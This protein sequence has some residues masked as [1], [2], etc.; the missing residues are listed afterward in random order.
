MRRLACV[1]LFLILVLS[2]GLSGCGGSKSSPTSTAKAASV[3][4]L[5]TSLSMEVGG[6]SQVVITVKDAAGNLLFTST[7]TFSSSNTAVGT[8]ANGGQVCAGT[9]DSLTIPVVC[10][11]AVAAGTSNLTATVGGITSNTVVLST[12]LH[13]DNITL[14]P[15]SVDCKSQNATQIF[16]ATAFNSGVDI[17]AT[18]GTFSWLSSDSTVATIDVAG[19][20]TTPVLTANQ[21]SIK[22]KN[23]GLANISASISGTNSVAAP[24][25]TCSP[26]TISIH[27]QS[28]PDTSFSIATGATKQLAA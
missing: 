13:V 18:V 24:F 10:T 5:P 12:H 23:S 1:G 2:L 8:V 14:S 25:I 16:T 26:A 20:A 7:P 21:A 19:P 22:A 11:P 28:L 27:V 4:L 6:V 17:T 3:A 9:W 15:A